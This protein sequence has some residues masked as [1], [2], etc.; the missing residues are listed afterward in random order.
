MGKTGAATPQLLWPVP[1]ILEALTQR[2][3]RSA[4]ISAAPT[5]RILLFSLVFRP[6][7]RLEDQASFVVIVFSV[8]AAMCPLSTA[9]CAERELAPLRLTTEKLEEL[10][11]AFKDEIIKG[12]A[13]HKH[14]GLKWVPEEC[15]LRMLDSCVSVVPTGHEKGVFYALDFGGTNV[16]A[17]R[18]ELMGEGKI[19]SKQSLKNLYECGGDVN[20]MARE[21]SASQLFDVLA[22]CVSE[23]VDDQQQDREAFNKG[24]GLL[25]FTF[26]FPCTQSALDTSILEAWTK[27]FKTGYDTTD[28][29]V[30]QDVV[31]LLDAAILRKGLNVKCAAVVNDTVGT[32][33]SCAYQKQPGSPP[34]SVGVIL[35]TGAN[36]CYVEPEAA[37]NGY[38]GRVIN[39]ECGNFNKHLPT[40][41]V[42]TAIDEKSPNKGEQLFEK[43]ISGFYLGELVR[44]LTLRI[45]GNA[46]PA[47]AKEEFSLDTKQV[48]ILACT[49]VPGTPVDAAAD[50]KCRDT[51]KESW[52]W[53]TDDASLKIMKDIAFAVFDRSAALAAISIAVLA[54]RT[55]ELDNNGSLT[56]AVDGSLYVR[57]AWY[58]ER[59]SEYMKILTGDKQKRI[60]LRAADD[61]SGKGAAICVAALNGGYHP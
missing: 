52:C 8:P 46:A 37:A 53:E 45:F 41:S 28:P 22:A 56:V 43:M 20:L 12:L 50:Q 19:V 54:E 34:C 9:Q 36:C 57:N 23:L 59:I 49:C 17:V 48:A 5:I 10:A 47:K 16:R 27:G 11:A 18:C 26:S 32:M 2:V 38:K 39:V 14:H 1:L 30:G 55:G 58:G 4:E 7:A 44:L 51:L 25:G 13:M 3:A 40:T 15:S 6:F 24:P 29:V 60:T 21:T 31:T 61:G 35:G 33:L 42:D